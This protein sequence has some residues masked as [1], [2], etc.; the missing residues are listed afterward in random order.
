MACTCISIVETQLGGSRVDVVIALLGN[1]MEARP[2]IRL[3]RSDTGREE[4]RRG[5]HSTIMPTFCP[6]C[7]VRYEPAPAIPAQGGQA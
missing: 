4:R 1:T 2:R 3:M 7:G 6:F 5:R